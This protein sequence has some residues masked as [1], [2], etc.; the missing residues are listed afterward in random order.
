MYAKCSLSECIL[1]NI[2]VQ[3]IIIAWKFRRKNN[4]KVVSDM[5]SD[6]SEAKIHME[7][8]NDH[9]CDCNRFQLTCKQI[10]IS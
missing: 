6:G 2:Y 8:R 1:C 5:K 9:V 3:V 10:C 4:E 7:G